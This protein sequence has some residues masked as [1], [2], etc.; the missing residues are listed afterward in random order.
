MQRTILHCDLNGFYASVECLYRPEIRNLPVVVGGDVDKRHGIILAKNQIA[1][2]FNIKTGEAL[3]QARQK[4]PN[5]VIIQPNFN[6]YLRFSALVRRIFTEYSDLIEPFGIDEAWIDVTHSLIKGTGKEIADELRER[7]KSE[8]GITASVGVSFN[9]IF[10]KLGSDIKKP[11]ATTVITKSNMKEIVFPLNASELLYVGRATYQKLIK[12]NIFTIGDIA[13]ADLKFLKQH[14]GK[15]GE[16]LWLFANG[17]ESSPV[18]P[19]GA[20]SGVKSI[21][22]S[23]TTPRD[24]KN[25][26]DLKIV[27]YVL[28]E[29]VGA[30]LREQGLKGKTI[31]V[32]IRDTSL[33]SFTRQKKL[34]FDTDCDKE[35]VQ[36]ALELFANNT[37]GL[38]PLRSIG[39][40]I[41]D[42]S[43]GSETR[44]LSLF[45]DHEDIEK[46]RTIDKTV[47]LIR[48][49][50]GFSTIKRGIILTDPTLGDFNPKSDHIIFPVGYF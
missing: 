44:Q 22:N 3:W 40:S 25:M 5:L 46:E 24:L 9:K 38:F 26:S 17:L 28:A 41:S 15:H 29:S 50:Y 35:I 18:S 4:C 20:D 23:T 2:K 47:D 45:V 1:K 16:Y 48:K 34:L 33:N 14:F 43:H 12:L 13:N 31:S 11:D 30:R 10:A 27:A 37:K 19:Y 39:I 6:R 32:S 7:I 8:V 42:L 21:G 49:R 36:T